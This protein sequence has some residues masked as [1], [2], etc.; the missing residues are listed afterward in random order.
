MKYFHTFPLESFDEITA[1]TL[2]QTQSLCANSIY[3]TK[4]NIPVRLRNLLEDELRSYNLPGVV[5]FLVFKR[6]KFF[7]LDPR[8]THIDYS[9]EPIHASIVLPIEGFKNTKMYWADGEYR[10]ETATL[11]HGSPYQKIIWGE[12]CDVVAETEIMEPTLCR[13]DIPHS[14]TSNADGSYRTILS[15]RLQNNPTFEEILNKRYYKN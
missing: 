12:S 3:I 1:H 7:K 9:T 10:C 2:D 4:I 14:A 15:I 8:L 5:N 13:V 11:P 6:S